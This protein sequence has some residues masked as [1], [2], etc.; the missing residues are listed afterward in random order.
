MP[1][2]W[3]KG[4]CGK[5]SWEEKCPRCGGWGYM[6]P[7]GGTKLTCSQCDGKKVVCADCKKAY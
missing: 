7:H 6:S 5:E 1:K 3:H 2:K 4:G